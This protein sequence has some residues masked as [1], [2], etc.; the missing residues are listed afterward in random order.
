MKKNKINNE[1][2]IKILKEKVYRIIDKIKPVNENTRADSNFLF[3][4]QKTEASKILPPHYLVYF[5]LVNLLGF[6]NLGKWEK[7]AWSIPIDY[8]GEA[9]LIEYRKFGLGIFAKDAKKQEKEAYK[10]AKLICKGIKTAQPYF[11]YLA[12]NAIETSNINVINKSYKLYERFSYFLKEYEKN[13]QKLKRLKDKLPK[14]LSIKKTPTKNKTYNDLDF[15]EL[16]LANKKAETL[17]IATIDSFFSWTEHIFIHLAI[18]TGKSITGSDVKTLINLDWKDKYKKIFSTKNN[19]DNYY[20]CKLTTI[21]EQIRNYS[22]HGAFGKKGEAFSF[23]SEAGAVPVFL[24]NTYSSNLT[25]ALERKDFE[26]V[27]S[28]AIDI[29]KLFIKYLWTDKYKIAKLYIQDTDL[30]L[31][32]TL[33]K[34]NIYNTALKSNKNMKGLIKSLYYEFD[35]AANMDW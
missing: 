8:N 17:A 19:M 13:S 35:T 30:P 27:D 24:Q 14:K 28:E 2:D 22:T 26:F 21:K 11:E 16:Y 5:F 10:I 3:K 6:K 15:N 7:I 33:A 4:A 29:I 34:N 9:Y 25:F 1:D 31:I 18:L 32:L 23:H 20:L 12:N